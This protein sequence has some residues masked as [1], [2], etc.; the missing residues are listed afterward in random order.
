MNPIRPFTGFF[1]L[2]K[3][4]SSLRNSLVIT[5]LVLGSLLINSCT[6]TYKA[7]GPFTEFYPSVSGSML[8]SLDQTILVNRPALNLTA[9]KGITYWSED[10]LEVWIKDSILYVREQFIPD[11]PLVA[12]PPNQ[13][14]L[15]FN[16]TR[17]RGTRANLTTLP[18][19]AKKVPALVISDYTLGEYRRVELLVPDIA[20]YLFLESDRA[21]RLGSVQQFLA[22]FPSANQLILALKDPDLV[23]VAFN[24]LSELAVAQALEVSGVEL[25]MSP[26][27]AEALVFEDIVG[28]EDQSERVISITL[29]NGIFSGQVQDGR[30]NGPG[31]IEYF[32]GRVF[33]GSFK[34]GL[35]HGFGRLVSTS[36]SELVISFID[37]L[38]DGSGEFRTQNGTIPVVYQLGNRIDQFYRDQILPVYTELRG[39]V[40]TLEQQLRQGDPEGMV[41]TTLDTINSLRSRVE[42][43]S[44]PE[45]L[46]FEFEIEDRVITFSRSEEGLVVSQFEEIRLQDEFGETLGVLSKDNRL[47]LSDNA[48]TLRI[49]REEVTR[50]EVPRTSV[51][52][53]NLIIG[54]GGAIQ[55]R[56][57]YA[58]GQANLA[59]DFRYMNNSGAN[60]PGLQGGAGRGWDFRG[61]AL[62]NGSV[63]SF[64]G[65]TSGYLSIQGGG[66]IGRTSYTFEPAD[67]LT[68]EQAGRG[69]TFGLRLLLSYD[70]IRPELDPDLVAVLP[71]SLTSRFKLLPLPFV[72]FETYRY[73]PGSATYSMRQFTVQLTWIGVYLSTSVVSF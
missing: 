6:T 71:R 67:L 26:Q 66:S 5:F 34:N 8:E 22:V 24:F 57:K 70:L 36:G 38:P 64:D 48:L 41:F 2:G 49:T 4:N 35:F 15:V 33:D 72:S 62:V 59:Y 1:T 21:N 44:E 20:G 45:R 68:L 63:S 43:T 56:A 13:G 61:S 42:E 51:V 23:E 10:N 14:L 37:G 17:G 30:P 32:D 55:P 50:L 18:T 31:R 47:V 73:S 25:D 58:S 19:D 40:Q 54:G 28:S 9:A 53:H 46:L 7:Q 65:E 16:L 27:V 69:T 11:D 52:F 12:L 39:A 60:L 3:L 29:S